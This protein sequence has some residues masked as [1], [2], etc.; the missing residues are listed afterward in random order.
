MYMC[1]CMSMYF[2]YI[3]TYMCIFRY[4]KLIESWIYIIC[5][6]YLGDSSLA[7]G[8]IADTEAHYALLDSKWCYKGIRRSEDGLGGKSCVVVVLGQIRSDEKV[9]RVKGVKG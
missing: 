6:L 2:M 3:Y 1:V 7:H 8:R 5:E 9:G 4:H